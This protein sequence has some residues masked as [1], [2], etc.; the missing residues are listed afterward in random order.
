MERLLSED[1]G[2]YRTLALAN[3]E[4]AEK[5]KLACIDT[6]NSGVIVAGKAGAGLLPI[7]VFME[8]FTG[9]G[10]RRIHI[11]FHRE[12]QG[13]WWDNDSVAPI[14]LTDRGKLCFLKDAQTVSIDDTGRS[15]AGMVLDVSPTD[16]VLVVFNVPPAVAAATV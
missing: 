6:A 14:A 11:K 15:P 13:T 8:S 5:G 9:D 4:V 3:G 1:Q 10:T 7:G 2:G 12:Y 16:G